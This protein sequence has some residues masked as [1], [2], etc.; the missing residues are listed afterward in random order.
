MGLVY[1]LCCFFMLSLRFAVLFTQ[2]VHDHLLE[3]ES[4]G[5]LDAAVKEAFRPPT[6][7]NRC[8]RCFSTLFRA[9][10]R[11]FW[12]EASLTYFGTL[13]ETMLSLFMSITGGVSWEN[14]IMPL[15]ASLEVISVDLSIA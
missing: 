12:V 13:A 4:E 15:K 8:F 7:Q 3:L 14:V 5:R 10:S 11:C 9:L 1:R 2:A 6:L